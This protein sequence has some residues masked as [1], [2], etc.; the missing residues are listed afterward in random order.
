MAVGNKKD[1]GLSTVQSYWNAVYRGLV[2]GGLNQVP[3]E[4]N[5]I[6]PDPE[7]IDY[8]EDP[9]VEPDNEVAIQQSITPLPIV[10][11]SDLSHTTIR[12]EKFIITTTANVSSVGTTIILPRN[13][14]RTQ[15]ILQNMGPGI[16]TIGHNESV[17]VSG[18]Q[19]PMGQLIVLGTTREI[20]AI[21][22]TTG[23]SQVSVI[24]EYDKDVS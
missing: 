12:V 20:W 4:Y 2:P 23:I 21:A 10:L 1:G 7:P 24:Q 16:V 18:F 19:I 3:P 9:Y 15:T 17:G 6:G 14:Y 22:L 5:D 11:V 8:P 13:P